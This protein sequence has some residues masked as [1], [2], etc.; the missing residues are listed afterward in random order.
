MGY[1][2]FRI[3]DFVPEFDAISAGYA[4]ASDETRRR[5]RHQLDV[6]YG[7]EPRQKLDLLFPE[8]L[9]GPAPVHI[10]V[11]GGYWRSFD[12]ENYHFVAESVLAAGAIAVIVEYTLM[13]GAR[14]AQLVGEVRQAALWV[15]AHIAEHGGDPGRI[16]ASGHSA[17]AHLA[18]YLAALAP[19]EHGF[20]AIPIRSLLL[21]SGI[22]DLRPIA[23]SF[24]QAELG[25]TADEVNEW[26]PFE[27]VQAPGTRITLAVGKTETEPFHLQAQDFA[28]AAERRGVDVERMTLSGHDHMTIV[29]DMGVPESR[30]GQLV[31]ETIA[32]S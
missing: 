3:R 31:R 1:D 15:G 16:S 23:E 12:R 21:A 32:R 9:D 14:M 19:H 22:Y 7:P 28:F 6:A 4:K 30:M 27:A 24:L 11:H 20:P 5:H 13:P 26:S 29:R 8:G 18:S 10:F 2:P 17:G 25:L